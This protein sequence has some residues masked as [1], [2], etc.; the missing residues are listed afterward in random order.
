MEG[1]TLECLDVLRVM[2]EAL[3]YLERQGRL[4]ARQLPLLRHLAAVALDGA[5]IAVP[6]DRFGTAG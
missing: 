5:P 1:A 2:R 3:P 4:T 6:F